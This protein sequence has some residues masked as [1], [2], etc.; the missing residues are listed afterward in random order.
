MD[1]IITAFKVM[2]T[3]KYMA[4]DEKTVYHK[5]VQDTSWASVRVLNNISLSLFNLHCV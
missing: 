3:K 1:N 2:Q 5:N 4:E